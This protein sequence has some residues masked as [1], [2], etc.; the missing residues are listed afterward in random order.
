MDKAVDNPLFKHEEKHWHVIASLLVCDHTK[1]MPKIGFSAMF[2]K[3]LPSVTEI[4]PGNATKE[5]CDIFK[6]KIPNEHEV[7]LSK[8]MNLLMRA[9]TLSPDNTL[10]P[11][12]KN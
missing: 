6:T 10:V 3:S 9:P 12:M 7:T 8:R 5:M 1:R 2:K 4:N 11:L